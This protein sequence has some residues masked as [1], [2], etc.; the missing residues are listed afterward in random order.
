MLDSVY[1]RAFVQPH[2][3]DS[4]V[5]INESIASS[6]LA[7]ISSLYTWSNALHGRLA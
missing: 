2:S 3:T 5:N 6:E 1:L 7:V 4:S